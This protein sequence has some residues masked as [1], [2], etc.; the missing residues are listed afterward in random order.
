ME[1]EK[2][3]PGTVAYIAPEVANDMEWSPA[4]DDFALAMMAAE[5]LGLQI[6]C[7]DERQTLQE[8]AS[9]DYLK[10]LKDGLD[11]FEQKTNRMASRQQ[12]APL[13]NALWGRLRTW[14]L[15]TANKDFKKRPERIKAL[16]FL[17]Q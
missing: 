10:K 4:S 13:N 6:I 15:L 8:R 12:D 9:G 3:G 2:R 14:L 17:T 7:G 16:E 1:R 5:T 11:Q